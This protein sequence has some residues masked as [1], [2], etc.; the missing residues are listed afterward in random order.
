MTWNCNGM[1]RNSHSPEQNCRDNRPSL[2]PIQQLSH[3]IQNVAVFNHLPSYVRKLHL[4]PRALSTLDIHKAADAARIGSRFSLTDPR[5][6]DHQTLVAEAIQVLA[7]VQIAKL[8][9][10]SFGRITKCAFAFQGV[11]ADLNAVWFNPASYA[12]LRGVKG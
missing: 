3:L 4:A 5:N 1:T 6:D 10:A 9:A 11:S 7:Q 2:R 8:P 12:G